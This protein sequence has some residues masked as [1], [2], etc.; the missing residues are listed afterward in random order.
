MALANH[1][2]VFSGDRIGAMR[3]IMKASAQTLEVEGASVWL[4]NIERIK[5]CCEEL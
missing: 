2:T 4:Y 5:I 3:L 1:K